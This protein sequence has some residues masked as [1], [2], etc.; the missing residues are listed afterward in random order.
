MIRKCLLLTVNL[1]VVIFFADAQKIH[2]AKDGKSFYSNEGGNIIKTALPG[3]N[4]QQ[5]VNKDRLLVAGKAVDF[6]MEDFALIARCRKS[7]DFYQ[8][9]KG[10]AI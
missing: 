7:V 3:F 5:I 9:R 8:C 2:W 6:E 10:L 4:T 1:F